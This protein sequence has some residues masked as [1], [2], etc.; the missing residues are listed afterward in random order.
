MT[1]SHAGY[2]ALVH[3]AGSKHAISSLLR[4]ITDNGA[5]WS[6][7]LTASGRLIESMAAGSGRPVDSAVLVAAVESVPRPLLREVSPKTPEGLQLYAFPVGADGKATAIL[8]IAVGNELDRELHPFGASAAVLLRLLLRD[9]RRVQTASRMV[10][11]SVTRLMFSGRLDSAFELAAE[12]GLAA[13]PS[14][15]HIACVRGVSGWDR[16][17][18]LDLLEAATPPEARQLL[19]YY[20]DDECWLVLSSVQFRAVTPELVA[21]VERNPALKTLLTE[22]VPATTLAHRWQHWMADIRN[23]PTGVV[24]DRSR[25]RGETPSD[26]V[27]RLQENASPQVVEA[28]VAYLRHRGRWE[29]AADALKIHRNTL[30]YRVSGAEKLLSL[31][32]ADPTPASRLWLAL[33][34]EGLAD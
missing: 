8:L 32:L 29:A 12:M 16:D 6:A 1:I 25:Y 20:D 33:C 14:R 2:A 19:A 5:A 21:L 22:Q 15:P 30:R 13:P 31:D 10:R 11:D 23:A 26:W 28:V 3:A 34:S 9:T 17:D 18:L 7:L 24:V 27:N 4:C